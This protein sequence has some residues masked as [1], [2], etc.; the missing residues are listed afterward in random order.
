MTDTQTE[1]P[2]SK[3]PRTLFR[4]GADV[5]PARTINGELHFLL[6]TMGR[7]PHQGSRGTVGGHL[8]A[9]D[10]F[11]TAGA[12]ELFEEAG[13]MADPEELVSLGV[14]DAVDRDVRDGVRGL[15][16]VFLL[17]ADRVGGEPEAGDDVAAVEWIAVTDLIKILTTGSEE[18]AYDHVQGLAAAC[19]HVT[20]P[21]NW[22]PPPPAPR[23]PPL[24][25]LTLREQQP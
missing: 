11:R 7:G 3:P 23:L 13:L 4:A 24:A 16:C 22:P 12:R 5:I 2:A 10:T 20:T 15:G 1:Q 18:F 21:G 8:D 25:K 14:L 17:D 9:A 6:A 19:L